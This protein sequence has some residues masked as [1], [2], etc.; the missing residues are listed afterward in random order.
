[1]NKLIF[2]LLAIVFALPLTYSQDKYFV[3]F[4]DKNGTP[5]STDNPEAYLSQRSI[6]R[7]N[8]QGIEIIERDLPVSP[9]YIERV[10]QAGAKVLYP[11]KWFNGVV[12]EVYSQ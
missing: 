4:T 12:V 10:E 9:D 6:E 7:R 11:L 2:T 8:R 1:M 5:Y 3:A